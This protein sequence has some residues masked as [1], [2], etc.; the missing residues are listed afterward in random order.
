MFQFAKLL[1]YAEADLLTGV[2]VEI[3]YRQLEKNERFAAA[4]TTF[5]EEAEE[6]VGL[7]ILKLVP[8]TIDDP[9][10]ILGVGDEIIVAN[11]ID[12]VLVG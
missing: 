11:L 10:L 3:I 1:E 2:S 5:D 6:L 8:T 4:G 9:N 7:A 12:A